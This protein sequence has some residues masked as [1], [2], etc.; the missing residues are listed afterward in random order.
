MMLEINF[1]LDRH[2]AIHDPSIRKHK[3]HTCGYRTASQINPIYIDMPLGN[4]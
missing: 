1:L 4:G 3:C 2:M